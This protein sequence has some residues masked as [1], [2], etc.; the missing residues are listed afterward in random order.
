MPSDDGPLF[1]T[2][3]LSV[4]CA[5]GACG[6]NVSV[7]GLTLSAF[8]AANKAF[9]S[10]SVGNVTTPPACIPI[11]VAPADTVHIAYSNVPSGP[12]CPNGV[13]HVVLSEHPSPYGGR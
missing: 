4:D 8:P 9:P 1:V 2:V 10:S 11:I 3:T 13:V 7:V 6:P 12:G 5:P